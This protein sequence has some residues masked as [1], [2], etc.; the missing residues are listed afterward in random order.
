MPPPLSDYHVEM[1]GFA[2]DPNIDH[3][4]S[5]ARRYVEEHNDRLEE[6][7]AA[8]NLLDKYDINEETPIPIT[9][10]MLVTAWRAYLETVKEEDTPS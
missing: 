1:Y 7:P 2:G 5:L 9:D 8:R 10:A 3:Q 6:D 4:A